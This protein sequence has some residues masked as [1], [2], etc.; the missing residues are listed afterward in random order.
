MTVPPDA[1]ASVAADV[2]DTKTIADGS[3]SYSVPLVYEQGEFMAVV[4]LFASALPFGVLA[5]GATS[6][7]CLPDQLCC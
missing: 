5:E 4:G 3:T 1:S 7:Q 2:A 6:A